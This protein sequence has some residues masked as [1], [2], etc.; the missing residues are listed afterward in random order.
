T[1][2]D[3]EPGL[4]AKLSH[5]KTYFFSSAKNSEMIS[6][7]QLEAGIMEYQYGR[8]DSIEKADDVTDWIQD[9]K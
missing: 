5:G 6:S 2:Q 9:M 1:G 4:E 7:P 3:D 8:I